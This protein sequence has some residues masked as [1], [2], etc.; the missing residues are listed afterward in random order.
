MDIHVQVQEFT[1]DVRVGFGVERYSCKMQTEDVVFLCFL[2]L[3]SEGLHDASQA[4]LCWSATLLP[5]NQNPFSCHDL[6]G[7]SNIH[8]ANL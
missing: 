6:L 1:G 2:T 7:F 4:L 8:L 3:D 5:T